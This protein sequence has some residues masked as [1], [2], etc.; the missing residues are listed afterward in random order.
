MPKISTSGSRG[1]AVESGFRGF[2]VAVRPVWYARLAWWLWLL[3]RKINV[4]QISRKGNGGTMRVPV[5]EVLAHNVDRLLFA[6]E[7]DSRWFRLEKFYIT[8]NGEGRMEC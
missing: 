8:R 4:N 7:D 5:G 6:R 2:R 3:P 1:S